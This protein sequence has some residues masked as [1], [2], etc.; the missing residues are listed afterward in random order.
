MHLLCVSF[1]AY[2]MTNINNLLLFIGAD[3]TSLSDLCTIQLL[4]DDNLSIL[5]SISFISGCITLFHEFSWPPCSYFSLHN[6]WTKSKV[7]KQQGPS[8]RLAQLPGGSS[9]VKSTVSGKFMAL[10]KSPNRQV[11]IPT[12]IPHT[13]LDRDYC[14]YFG[15]TMP[16]KW[17]CHSKLYASIECILI[18][19]LKR[20][21]K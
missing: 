9:T 19:M 16:S 4:K 18:K 13:K 20:Y 5:I 6:L 7:E 17:D 2:F 8:L 21:P 12:L 11:S 14:R 15:K 3:P 10:S 1:K